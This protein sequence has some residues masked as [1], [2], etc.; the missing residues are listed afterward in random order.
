MDSRW[1][2]DFPHLS[3]PVL[4]RIKLPMG[5]GFFLGLKRSERGIDNP[6]HL[7]LSLK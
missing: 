3:R 1:S 6:H 5:T 2:R 4:C 7:A